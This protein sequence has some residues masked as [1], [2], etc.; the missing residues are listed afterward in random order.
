[1]P[2]KRK[3]AEKKES[4]GT[5]EVMKNTLTSPTRN[6]I[7]PSK[8]ASN[9]TKT[10]ASPVLSKRKRAQQRSALKKLRKVDEQVKF[11]DKEIMMYTIAN[12][13]KCLI[14]VPVVYSATET[15]QMIM[16]EWMGVEIPESICEFVSKKLKDVDVEISII[17][18]ERPLKSLSRGS[19]Y[20]DLDEDKMCIV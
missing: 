5:E 2:P 4:I 7:K 16:D 17:E 14:S 12:E 1:M 9:K 6:K 3:Y 15:N 8:F 13:D 18:A 11:A 10:S 20:Y 19:D